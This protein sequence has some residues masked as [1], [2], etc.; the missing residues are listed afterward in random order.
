MGLFSQSQI[1]EINAVAAKSQEVLKP[2]KVS[3]SLSSFQAEIQKSSAAVLDYF[4][5]SPAILIT[6]KQELHEYVLKAIESG[7][8]GIDTETTGLDRIQDS[9]VGASLYYPGGVECYIPSKHV[10]PIFGTPYK[11]QLTYEDVAKELQ[12]FVDAK[13]KMIFANAD[14]DIAFIYKDYHVDMIDICYYDCILAWRCLKENEPQNDLKTLYWKYPNKQQG[15]PKKFSDFFDHKLFP[16][17]RPEVAKLYAA[18]DAKITFELF[19]WQ[20]PF[21]TKSHP[22][23]QKHHLEKIA[24]LVWNIEFPL[25]KVCALMHRCGIFLDLD[26]SKSLQNRYHKLLEEESA[27]LADMVQEIISNSDTLTLTKA[28]FKTG[29]EF[30]Q[31]SPPQVKY[32]LNSFMGLQ[33]DSSNKNILNELNLPV[34]KQILKVRSITTLLG[35]FIDKLPGTAGPDGRVHSTFKSIGADTGRMSSENPN[36][37][38]IPSHA[39]DVRHQF[40]ATPAMEKI[41]KCDVSEN[42]ISI[43]L[44]DYD[45]IDLED[46]VDVKVKDLRVGDKVRLIK[47][48]SEILAEITSLTNDAPYTLITM[49]EVM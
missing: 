33:V 16:F 27:K 15:S 30:N 32:L 49:Q 6:S 47:D 39:L 17:C 34:T 22:K 11:G 29:K 31:S 7:Y 46:K 4:K 18:N 24:D 36:V 41:D 2:I 5:D 1:D 44:F 20:L 37:Q 43:N 48:R 19:K 40:R 28:P 35:S 3:K 25:I 9:I 13:T 26:T 8:C 14:F 45:T 21:I 42:N 12:R 10:V 38:N 23:C